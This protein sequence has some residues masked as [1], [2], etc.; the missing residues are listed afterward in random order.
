MKKL[1]IGAAAL[2]VVT[3]AVAQVAA[4]APAPQVQRAPKAMKVHTRAE[5]Q[6]KIAEHF[7]RLDTNRDGFVTK[8]EADAARAQFA[9]RVRERSGERREKT[10]DRLDT[11]NDGAISKVEWDARSAQRGQRMAERA[12]GGRR[13]GM[14]AMHGFGGRMFEMADANRDGRVSLQEAQAAAL[15]HFD[16]VDAN[17]DGQITREERMQMRQR[18]RAQHQR[19]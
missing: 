2:A 12:G 8:A 19:G 4:Q 16:M 7:A 6:T 18:M 13:H 17:R 5:V 9:S 14:G 1:L 10:F 3:P 11:N 15:Q